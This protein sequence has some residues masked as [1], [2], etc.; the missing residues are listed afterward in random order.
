MDVLFAYVIGGF[1]ASPELG[2][3]VARDVRAS[4]RIVIIGGTQT[5]AGKLQQPQI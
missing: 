2:Q 5:L 4:R 1:P 3:P